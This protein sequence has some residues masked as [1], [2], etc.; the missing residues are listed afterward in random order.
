M[1]NK[2]IF[3]WIVFS[4]AISFFVIGQIRTD[5]YAIPARF[6]LAERT[7]FDL[8]PGELSFG[9]IEINQSASR[10]IT[11]FNNLDR[12]VEVSIKSYG[13]ISR[14]LAASENNFKL[15]AHESKEVMFSIDTRGLTELREY[16]GKVV[17]FSRG[18]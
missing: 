3:L 13:E 16:S 15:G 9:K 8:T 1:T 18:V 6:T 11:I 10:G 4:I 12:P 2:F 17:V 7:G 14:N 5:K